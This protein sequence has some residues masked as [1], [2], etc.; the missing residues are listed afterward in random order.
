[1]AREIRLFGLGA[2]RPMAEAITAGLGQPL[3]AL[4]E[5]EFEDGEHKARPLGQVRDTDVYVVHSLY[6]DDQYSECTT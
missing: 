6:A 1:M 5:Q 2:S 4:E 3:T